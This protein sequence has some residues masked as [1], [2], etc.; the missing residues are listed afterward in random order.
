MV[1]RLPPELLRLIIE[2]TLPRPLNSTSYK[3][4][5]DTLRSFSLVS[6]RFRDIAQPLLSSDLWINTLAS[7]RCAIELIE[8]QQVH[9]MSVDTIVFRADDSKFEAWRSGNM[10]R[11]LHSCSN[12]RTLVVRDREMS[13]SIL[14]NLPG[15]LPSVSSTRAG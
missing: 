3:E 7:T 10:S 12:L 14:V 15:E 8:S 2:S 9:A 11:I 4:R 5:Q 1:S 6:S 13:F